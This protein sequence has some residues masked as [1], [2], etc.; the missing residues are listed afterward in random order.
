MVFL[1]KSQLKKKLQTLGVRVVGNYVRKDDVEMLI[2]GTIEKKTDISRLYS[3][4]GEFYKKNPNRRSE[5]DP[6]LIELGK[7]LGIEIP[8]IDNRDMFIVA[9]EHG[10]FVK[11]FFG[12]KDAEKFVSENAGYKYYNRTH[13]RCPSELKDEF[14]KISGWA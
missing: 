5:I 1:S 3:K 7:K 14:D 10:K 8:V 6:V 4:I 11:S 9:D 2:K 12:F 13:P